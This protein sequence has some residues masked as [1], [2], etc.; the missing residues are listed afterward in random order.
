VVRSTAED[1]G[2][3]LLLVAA[4]PR[5][6][7][8]LLDRCSSPRKSRARVDWAWTGSLRADTVLLTANGTG[9]KRAAAAVDAGC[10]VLRPE[11]V[12]ST[13]FCGALD[14]SLQVAEVVVGSR[15]EGNG[16][17]W[18][19]L[20]PS[21][22]AHRAGVVRSCAQVVQNT[23]EKGLLRACGGDIVEMEAA[24][25]AEASYRKGLP[26]FCVKAVTDLAGESFAIDFNAALREDG[27]FDTMR[28]LRDSL[29]CP[30]VCFPELLRLRN[31]CVRAARA[32]GDFFAECRF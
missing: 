20:P 10:E 1:G 28:I 29:R 3:N 11:A 27:H 17:S 7:R 24:A 22:P 9:W 2:V 21:G 5:E 4:E 19:A 15:V 6:L 32:L 26:F 31:R 13:G 16:G 25:V 23:R 30:A 18:P 8:P 12:I 14:P